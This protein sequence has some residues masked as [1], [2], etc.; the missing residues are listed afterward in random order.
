M[1]SGRPRSRSVQLDG[2]IE[3]D[4]T[5]RGACAGSVPARSTV[6]WAV[7]L[8]LGD[9]TDVAGPGDHEQLAKADITI[10]GP[11]FM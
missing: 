7:N 5:P 4:A 2:R 8:L 3:V 1:W 11:L 10:M 9:V 6:C